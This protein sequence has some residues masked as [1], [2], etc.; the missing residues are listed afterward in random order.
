V[1]QIATFGTLAARAAIRDVGRVLGVPLALVDR[2]SK[3]IPQNMELAHAEKLDDVKNLI[4]QN[5]D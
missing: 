4:S 5:P 1:A 2:L 3:S